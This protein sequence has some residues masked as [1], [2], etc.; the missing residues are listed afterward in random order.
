MKRYDK[1]RTVSVHVTKGVT[2]QTLNMV[3]RAQGAEQRRYKQA[4]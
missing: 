2:K 4:V 3:Y 1:I